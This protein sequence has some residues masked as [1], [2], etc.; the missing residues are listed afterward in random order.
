L[1][2][3]SI[4]GNQIEKKNQDLLT[5]MKSIQFVFRVFALSLFFTATL[6]QA[7]T[8]T[9]KVTNKTNGKPAAGDSVVLVDVQAGMGEVAHATTSANGSYSLNEPG[10][11]PYL[12]RVTHQGAGYFIAAPQGA[13]PAEITVYDVAAKVQGV[14][15]EADVL[16]IE[17]D[18]GQLKV[19]ERYFVHN[20]SSPPTTQWSAKSFEVVLP[21][22]AVIDGVGGQRPNGLPTSIKI[23]PDGPKGHYAFN[24]PIQPD[25]GEKDTLFQLAYHLPYSGGKYSFHAQVT[26][27]ADNLAVLLPK[28]MTFTAT[29]G[30]AFKTVPEETS[31]QTFVLKNAAPGKPVDF[32]VAGT[33]SI[34]REGQGTPGGQQPA[35]VGAQDASGAP[36]DAST[37]GPGGGIGNP[38]DTPDPLS[39]YKW[40]ILGSLALLFAAAAAF[41]LRKPPGTPVASTT[42]DPVAAAYPSFGSPAAKHTQL[43]NALKEELFA[44]ESEKINGAIAPEEYAQVKAALET[45]LKRAL[46]RK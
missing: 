17:S 42:T 4:Q 38:I 8:V 1:S 32:T 26:L 34:P 44:L 46:N 43:L 28:S 12:I 20:T 33:G 21:A 29:S 11:G 23:D 41:L 19:T 7:A 18:N 25:D 14:F 39:K 45:V 37:A 35:G 10:S 9:G 31:V 2:G 16:E 36:A 24:F 40:W 3:S 15:I 13:T 5:I 27:P 6:A 22:D 30:D